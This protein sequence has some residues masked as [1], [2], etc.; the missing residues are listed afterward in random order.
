MD[1]RARVMSTIVTHPLRNRWMTSFPRWYWLFQWRSCKSNMK[2]MDGRLPSVL[3]IHHSI[4][5]APNLMIVTYL[6]IRGPLLL[7]EF[8]DIFIISNSQS[9]FFSS[10]FYG[11]FYSLKLHNIFFCFPRTLSLQFGQPMI[12]YE[13][14]VK[15]TQG[16][17]EANLIG[18]GSFRLVYKGIFHNGTKVGV[19][20]LKL[21][22]E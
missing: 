22:N 21:H 14:L 5:G 4:G 17:N 16:F 6:R 11:F 19:K 10:L 13:D 15:S 2:Q 20:V 3:M 7:F 1:I 12:Y 8:I 18:V 9:Y